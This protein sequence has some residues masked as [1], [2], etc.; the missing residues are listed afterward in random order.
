MKGEEVNQILIINKLTKSYGLLKKK[1]VLN[2]IEMV[3]ERGKCL[4]IV[5]ENGSG[6]TTLLK[7]IGSLLP[8]NSGKVTVNGKISY[9]P[10]ISSFFPYL[11]A[12]ENMEYFD[13]LT[14]GSGNYKDMLNQ[15][16]IP[17]KGKNMVYFS[18]GMKRKI[19]IIRAL[20]P[21]PSLLILD[22]PFD[23][24]DP[25]SNKNIIEILKTSKERGVSII[26]SSH[27]MGYVERIADQI[28]LLKGGVFKDISMIG[29]Y[30]KRL[31]VQG[32]EKVIED[33]MKNF[34][35]IILKKDRDFILCLEKSDSA[36][37]LL[38]KLLDSGVRYIGEETESLEQI[39]I[40][41]L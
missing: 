25:Y 8:Y 2:G 17:I 40:K 13:T 36:N 4:S 15:F 9:V 12:G 31:V 37:D 33:T 20:N 39:Y 11:T 16:E 7:I 27:D 6:K 21:N 23:G 32:E 19:D 38:K 14:G 1:K 18:K 24:I 41:N 30:E 34:S 29:K 35:G 26:M 3:L 22:E 5:G 10:E 28:M